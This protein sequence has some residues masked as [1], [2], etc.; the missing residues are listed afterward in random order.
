M[1][2]YRRSTMLPVVISVATFL[3]SIARAQD[4]NPQGF[5]EIR[6]WNLLVVLENPLGG[7]PGVENLKE[8]WIAP[9][10]IS[11]IDPQAGDTH[12]DG[13]TFPA[14]DF[15]GASPSTG[16]SSGNIFPVPTWFTL[17]SLD[18]HLGLPDGTLSNAMSPQNVEFQRLMDWLNDNVT[19]PDPELG[20]LPSDNVLGLATTY[21]ENVTGAPLDV[22]ICTDSDDSLQVWVN[23][24]C[25][26]NVSQGRGQEGFCQDLNS[27]A[28]PVGV[29]RISVLNWE[30]DGGWG[31]RLAIQLDEDDASRLRDEDSETLVFLGPTAP[32]AEA[33]SRPGDCNADGDLDISDGIC[34]LNNLFL[35]SD[36]PLPCGETTN[37]EGNLVLLD[38]NGSGEVDVS[39]PV[40][41]FDYLFFAGLPPTLGVDCVEIPGCPGTCL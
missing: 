5:I 2:L 26:T 24:T 31:F 6:A 33:L 25:V 35:G 9:A 14:I 32:A 41:I 17:S 10:V 15:D 16:Y 7:D 13:G 36:L 18:A 4:F 28:L 19:D 12:T 40:Y 23:E 1:S 11:E 8:N 34:V 27:F 39:D 22:F 20:S 29:S 30:G 21:V 37:D 3:V 38:S